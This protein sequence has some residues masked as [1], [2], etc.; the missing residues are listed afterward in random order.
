MLSA[1]IA[2]LK[3]IYYLTLGRNDNVVRQ[4]NTPDQFQFEGLVPVVIRSAAVCIQ[5]NRY[6]VLELADNFRAGE[7]S[8]L[9]RPTVHS[10]GPREVDKEGL[11]LQFCLDQGVIV[12]A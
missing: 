9:H 1:M 12:I 11:L 8:P 10:S 6:E 2:A 5:L 4:R 3:S 7:D